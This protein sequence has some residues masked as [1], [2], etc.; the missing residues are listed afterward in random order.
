[1]QTTS[2]L[3]LERG[4]YMCTPQIK[5]YEFGRIEVDGNVYTADLIILPNRIL[6]A[7]WRE[8]GHVLHS[9]DLEAVFG[10]SPDVLIIG[11]GAYGRMRIANET[12]QAVENMGIEMIALPTHQ[13]VERY[14]SL[15][16]DRR[17]AAALHLTC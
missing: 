2:D 14:N 13:A 5:S 1:L 9:A 8:E 11:Q 6:D 7:W 12:E 16:V 10:A 17:V 15:S 4:A 3:G